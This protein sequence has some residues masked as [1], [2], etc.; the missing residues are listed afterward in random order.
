MDA[1]IS[2]AH[3]ILERGVRFRLPAPFY[4]RW[5]KKD[6]VTIRHLKAG[7][8]F[9][10]S[11]VVLESGIEQALI[12][13]DFEFLSKTIKSVAEC[14][15]IAILND[16]KAIEDKTEKLKNKLLWEVSSESLIELF[17]NI[18]LMNR[19]GIFT[20]ATRYLHRMTTTMMNPKNLGQKDGS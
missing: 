6:Y 16:K 18:V 11:C 19:V 4:K 8:I 7:T 15:A 1:R 5:L 9:E 12:A 2:A 14:I 10:I 13:G 20:T 17:N 3:A